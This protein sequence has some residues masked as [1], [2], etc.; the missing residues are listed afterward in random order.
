[1]R[2]VTLNP[3]QQRH[4]DILTRLDA[5][6]LDVPAA[7]LLLGVSP[8]HVRRLHAR[9]RAEGMHTVIHGNQDRSPANRTDPAVV[10]R[11]LDLAGPDGAY[12]D[13]NVCHLH[14]RLTQ[15]EHL[16]IGRS[17]LDRLQRQHG[18]R[19]R[20]QPSPGPHRRRRPRHAAEG[21]FLQMDGSPF[22][23]LEARGPRLTLLGAVDDAT[24]KIVSLL[25]RPTEDQVG[26]LL[27]LRTIAQT[28]G[29]LMAIS[30]DRHT[31]LRSP[32]QPTVEEEL[33]GQR[34]MSQVQRLL[35]DLD[36]ESIPAHSPQAKGRV[37]RLWGTLH[38]RVCRTIQTEYRYSDLHLS[39]ETDLTEREHWV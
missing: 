14:D 3:K 23:W 19:Q 25:F 15:E 6:T 7:A 24:G 32:K 28:H 26:Y 1:M 38:D 36:I 20:S 5:G 11:I 12:H 37:E 29:V 31:I 18:V 39:S 33:A 9:F 13:L 4:V 16:P 10:Q 17:T 30:H 34:P 22:D 8:R 21:M 27:L 2:T 35:A